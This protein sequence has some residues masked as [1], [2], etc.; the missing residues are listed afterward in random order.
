MYAK[1][2]ILIATTQGRFYAPRNCTY[3]IPFLQL[4]SQTP[5]D[6]ITGNFLLMS[7]RNMY[8]MGNTEH[9]VRLLH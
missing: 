4:Y 9:R 6:G 7:M 8:A 2:T 1:E 3:S 5:E